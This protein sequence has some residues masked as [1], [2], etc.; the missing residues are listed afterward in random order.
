ML[1]STLSIEGSNPTERNFC[2]KCVRVHCNVNFD[3]STHIK[4]DVKNSCHPTVR[5]SKIVAIELPI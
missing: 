1:N 5:S 3:I 2:E 4:S